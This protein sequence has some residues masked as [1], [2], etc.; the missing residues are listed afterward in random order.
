MMLFGI[1]GILCFS[2]VLN[3][4]CTA[5]DTSTHSQSSAHT[6][7]CATS[8]VKTINL[9]NAANKNPISNVQGLFCVQ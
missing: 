5:Y 3:A 8:E 7:D 2:L 4:A 1:A 9:T 6:A